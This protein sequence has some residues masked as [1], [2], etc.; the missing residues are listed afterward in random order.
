VDGK[1]GIETAGGG[2]M[3]IPKSIV[4]GGRTYTVEMRDRE[5]DDGL[6]K[7]ATVNFVWQKIWIDNK[8]HRELQ[9]TSFLHEIIEVINEQNGLKLEHDTIVQLEGA[10]FPALKTLE[11]DVPEAC[12][13]CVVREG[14]TV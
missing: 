2:E 14:G 7:C 5:K 12:K 8:T 11:G 10:L 9:E 13:V 3:R 6:Q 4:I 1:D